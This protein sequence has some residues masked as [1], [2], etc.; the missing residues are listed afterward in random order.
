MSLTL[1]EANKLSND[2]V[3]AGVIDA[4]ISES[5]L[6]QRLQFVEMI[7]TAY[8]YVRELVMAAVDW[9]AVGDTWVES[10]PTTEQITV[11]AKIC[12][13]DADIDNFLRAS[14]R[15]IND[16]EATTLI[17]K[18]KAWLY[19]LESKLIYGLVSSNAKHFDGLH[20]F[21]GTGTQQ[22]NQGSSTTGAALKVTG[23]RTLIDLVR[24]GKPD[25]LLTTRAVRRGLSTF[26]AAL[27][28]PV[29]YVPDQF[30]QRVMLFDGI[31][32]LTSDFM[33][34][35]E[36]IASSRYALPTT[37]AT[38][39]V[40]AIKIGEAE[41]GLVMGHTGDM[42]TIETIG[43]L[44]TKDATRHRVKSYGAPMLLG[45]LSLARL[46]GIASASA[47]VAGP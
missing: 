44:E 39:T 2:T 16:L 32:L 17:G 6:M 33:L 13:G 34:D 43:A 22:V 19:E 23:L 10:T 3:R 30:G 18:A 20:A 7:G 8:V 5:P 9:Y 45:A 42:P 12:G 28:S 36:T 38:S 29:S 40:F 24:P 46:D 47:V 26:A 1:T 37:G 11:T 4:V 41:N 21:I 35:T 25:F 14:R 27:T 31:P 15:N